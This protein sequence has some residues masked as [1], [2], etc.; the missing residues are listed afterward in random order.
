MYK[1]EA[2]KEIDYGATGVQEVLQNVAFIMSTVAMDCPLDREFG[3]ESVVD[4]PLPILKAMYSARVVGAVNQFEPRAIIEA[5][6]ITG[7]A[8]QGIFKAKAQVSV[9]GE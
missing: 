3:I 7:D 9:N 4:R 1:V 8:E 6:E 5:I 2:M